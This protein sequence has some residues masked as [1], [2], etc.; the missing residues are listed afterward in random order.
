MKFSWTWLNQLININNMHI[1][2]IIDQL[3][4]AGFELDRIDSIHTTNDKIIEISITPNRSDVSSIVGLAKEINTIFNTPIIKQFSYNHICTTNKQDKLKLHEK[5]LKYINYN[6]INHLCNNQSPQW[7]Q[8]YLISYDIE[9]TC[10]LED[11]IKY[12]Q[13][14]WNYN[15]CISTLDQILDKE[16]RFHLNRNN[17]TKNTLIQSNLII[18]SFVKEYKNI[19]TSYTDFQQAYNETINLIQTY[20]RATIGKIQQYYNNYVPTSKD[21]CIKKNKIN[22]ILGP[23]VKITKQYLST[24]EIINLLTQLNLQPTYD[25]KNKLFH[26][27]IPEHRIDDLTREIDIIEEISRI[28]GFNNFHDQLSKLNNY[29]TGNI[30]TYTKY[31]YNIRLILRNLGLHETLNSSFVYDNTLN[32]HLIKTNSVSLYNPMNEYQQLLRINIIDNLIQKYIYNY[33]QKNTQC[34]FFEIGKIFNISSSKPY[35]LY[36]SM[37]LGGILTNSTFSRTSWSE[38][39]M[40]MNWFHAKGIMEEFFHKLNSNISWKIYNKDHTKYSIFPNNQINI[41]NILKTVFIYDQV[42]NTQIGIFGQIDKRIFKNF[43]LDCYINTNIYAFEINLYQLI[44]TIPNKKHTEYLMKPYSSYP[45]ITRDISFNTNNKQ[46]IEN[47]INCIQRINTEIIESVQIFNEYYNNNVRSIGLRIIYRSKYRTLQTQEI[48]NT[49][50]QIKKL[51]IN[52]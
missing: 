17:Y 37:H 3:T 12:I 22:N 38:K 42:N 47:V 9:P 30:Q 4:L 5:Y 18:Y 36:E 33:K 31:I 20:G 24:S 40:H 50:L 16:Q 51:L 35:K 41:F 32:N 34:E 52:I 43:D 2:Q 21:I 13:L 11:I 26:I 15:I 7:I 39:P 45:S 46:N 6:K 44:N 25:K 10:L 23:I 27:I 14:K 49:H 29:Q 19:G 48:E 1:D 8:N 28:Y